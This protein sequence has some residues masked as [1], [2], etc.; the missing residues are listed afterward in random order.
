MWHPQALGLAGAPW[1]ETNSLKRISGQWRCLGSSSDFF[2][3]PANPAIWR[4][5]G[6]QRQWRTHQLSVIAPLTSCG[7]TA[8]RAHPH[9]RQEIELVRGAADAWAVAADVREARLQVLDQLRV[10]WDSLQVREKTVCLHRDDRFIWPKV[11]IYFNS[12][13]RLCGWI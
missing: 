1:P 11:N 6:R 8:T 13:D 12:S 5:W 4:C 10:P 9:C 3:C 7:I 2:P